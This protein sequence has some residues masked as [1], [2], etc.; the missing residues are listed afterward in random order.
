M[1]NDLATSHKLAIE[2]CVVRGSNNDHAIRIGSC[3]TR[4]ARHAHTDLVCAADAARQN[5]FLVCADGGTDFHRTTTLFFC[6]PTKVQL[7]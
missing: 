5:Y 2:L 4:T 7:T 3:N 6:L 1:I